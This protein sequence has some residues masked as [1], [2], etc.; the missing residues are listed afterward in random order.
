MENSSIGRLNQ[1]QKRIQ[2]ILVEQ[3]LWLVKK[4]C[5]SCDQP[6]YGNGQ[7]VATYTLFIKGNKCKIRKK[8]KKH[9]RR[10][11][12]QQIWDIY[13]EQKK[14]IPICYQKTLCIL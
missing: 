10:Y 5:L 12:K 13:N 6:K 4:V 2:V 7:N 11:T 1:V 8:A 3:R 14:L 9:S